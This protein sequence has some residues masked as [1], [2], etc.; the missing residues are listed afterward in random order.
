MRVPSRILALLLLCG[1]TACRSY[2]R[3]DLEVSVRG[4]D[5]EVVWSCCL[6]TL[7]TE[8][9]L[10]RKGVDR[11]RRRIETGW[12]V[13]PMPFGR[14]RRSRG[15]LEV[16]TGPG[17]THRIRFHVD[18]EAYGDMASPLDPKEDE[19]EDSGQ[20]REAERRLLYHLRSRLARWQRESGGGR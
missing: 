18:L 8:F 1:G 2:Y 4:L 17:G 9:P 13:R 3:D 5:F 19:W 11:G 12:R 6:E 15:V 20:D 14:G 10:V 16:E 7:R